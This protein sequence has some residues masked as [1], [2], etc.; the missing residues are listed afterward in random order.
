MH[1]VGNEED[2]EVA[3]FLRGVRPAPSH[4]GMARENEKMRASNS[5][6]HGY[7]DSGVT[8]G[9]QMEEFINYHNAAGAYYDANTGTAY[10]HLG[11]L[12][13]TQEGHVGNTPTAPTSPTTAATLVGGVSRTPS[14]SVQSQH[15]IQPQARPNDAAAGYHNAR[16]N[17]TAQGAPP[18]RQSAYSD[19]SAYA[20]MLPSARDPQAQP[21][22]HQQASGYVPS[23]AASPAHHTQ[24]ISAMMNPY[25]TDHQYQQQQADLPYAH[26]Q[27]QQQQQQ[28][29]YVVDNARLMGNGFGSSPRLGPTGQTGSYFPHQQQ[30]QHQQQLPA[31][32]SQ[33]DRNSLGL[34]GPLDAPASPTLQGAAHGDGSTAALAPAPRAVEED[35]EGSPVEETSPHANLR[36]VNASGSFVGKEG[37]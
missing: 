10:P 13:Y 5:L 31:Y 26:P 9:Y 2:E 14:A 20:G 18:A 32:A 19:D 28:H 15:S 7:T 25:S 37:E 29:P 34:S 22:L 1:G 17:L 12:S 8:E 4:G 16:N 30:Q 24:Q 33:Q 36:V 6:G 21:L 11:T 23:R 27:Y 3:G 35:G